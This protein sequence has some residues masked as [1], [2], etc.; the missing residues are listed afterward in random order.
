MTPITARRS[1]R[2]ALFPLWSGLKTLHAVWRQR[3]S[4]RNLDDRALA[5]IG[6]TRAE[7]MA[8]ATRPLW[9]APQTWCS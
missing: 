8:E 7:A 1:P 2:P 3:Q 6:V 5:D 9:D 4:L